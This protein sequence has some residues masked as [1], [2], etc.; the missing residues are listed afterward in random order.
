MTKF[1]VTNT[2]YH[3]DIERYA[4][5]IENKIGIKIHHDKEDY[6]YYVIRNLT[7]LLK[8]VDILDIEG[9]DSGVIV[10]RAYSDDEYVLEIYDDWRE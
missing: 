10:S 9:I 5:I 4:R 1:I 6:Y 2:G 7:T 8:I 3:E